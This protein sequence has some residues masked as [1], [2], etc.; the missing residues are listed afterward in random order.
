M[1]IM[2]WMKRPVKGTFQ[3]AAGVGEALGNVAGG[4]TATA[5]KV[6]T[7]PARAGAKVVGE[8]AKVVGGA[9]AHGAAA[10]AGVVRGFF[11]TKFG[12]ITGI[13]AMAGAALVTGAVLVGKSR[14]KAKKAEQ[15]EA[16]AQAMAPADPALET[17]PADGRS[18]THWQDTTARGG[19]Q[20]PGRA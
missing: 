10:G 8:S 7:A 3:G 4:V 19:A 2:D 14:G 11:K 5:A 15:D 18:S 20:I 12:K 6:V 17:G 1:G 13:G 16:L 9:T